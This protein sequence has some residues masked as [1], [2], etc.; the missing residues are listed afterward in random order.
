MNTGKK[1]VERAK[2]FTNLIK[3]NTKLLDLLLKSLLDSSEQLLVIVADNMV[4]YANRKAIKNFGFTSKELSTKTVDELFITN[5]QTPFRSFLAMAVTMRKSSSD[6]LLVKVGSKSGSDTWYSPRIKR[7]IWK[8]KS[9]LLMML[10]SINKSEEKSVDIPREDE[11]R[12]RMALKGANQGVWEFNLK[13]NDAYVSEE[14]FTILGYKPNE[15][16]PSYQ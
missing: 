2:K 16:K 14:S 15:F 4:V 11:D 5:Q 12:I 1:R 3:E 7:C 13:T 10:V 6:Q 8:G 9:S